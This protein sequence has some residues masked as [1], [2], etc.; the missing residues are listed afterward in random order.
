MGLDLLDLVYRLERGLGVRIT[1]AVAGSPLYDPAFDPPAGVKKKGE[2]RPEKQADWG[3]LSFWLALLSD[4]LFFGA[5]IHVHA[6]RTRRIPIVTW[7]PGGASLAIAAAMVWCTA[8]LLAFTALRR[9]VSWFPW[10]L[11]ALFC[12]IPA[13]CWFLLYLGALYET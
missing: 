8:V 9:S 4:C 12:A 11:G 6:D 7:E 2:T 13:A 1:H 10:A 5:G 3:R